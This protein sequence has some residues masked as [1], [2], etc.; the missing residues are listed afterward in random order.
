MAA[1]STEGL[2]GSMLRCPWLTVCN[3]LWGNRLAASQHT[4]GSKPILFS[5][6]WPGESFIELYSHG[7]MESSLYDIVKLLLTSCTFGPLDALLNNN[8]VSWDMK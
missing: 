1:R 4:V 6:L 5:S 2:E 7:G 3:V 8:L